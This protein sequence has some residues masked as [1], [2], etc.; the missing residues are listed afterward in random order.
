MSSVFG[1]NVPSHEARSG[2]CCRARLCGVAPPS[3]AQFLISLAPA[4]SWG[5]DYPELP[6]SMTNSIT[7]SHLM[8]HRYKDNLS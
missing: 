2:S 5:S 4:G 3:L 8:L 7:V 6:Q 1:S